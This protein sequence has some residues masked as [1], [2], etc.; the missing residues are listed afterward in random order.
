[1][2]GDAI[3]IVEAAY[4]LESDERDWGTKLLKQAAPRL[5]RGFGV[6]LA[7]FVPGTGFT[8]SSTVG[9]GMAAKL[10]EAMVALT[11]DDPEGPRRFLSNPPPFASGTQARGLTRE[12][13][14][15]FPPLVTRLHPLGVRDM[16]VV[17]VV[18][19]DTRP[20][21]LAAPTHD[22][23]RVSRK[24]AAFWARI[25]AHITAGARLRRSLS[26]LPGHVAE[27]KAEAVLSPSGALLH[28][29]PGA[30]ASSARESLR[31]AAKAIDRARSKGRSD[32]EEALDLWRG[33]VSGRWS[34][35]DQFDTDGRR[36]L[37]ALK[38]DPQVSDPRVLSLRERQVLAYTALG[39]SLKLI[40]YT[41]GFSTSNVAQHRANAMR[42]LGL[43]SYADVARL[44]ADA[45]TTT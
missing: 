28:A 3:S 45:A 16:V 1:V 30:Q 2:K 6:A 25:V 40:A 36:F 37:V 39:Y 32:D 13:A 10:V 5:E 38:N 22:V 44:F 17:S 42:K 24:D 7:E 8:E 15:T 19:P 43:T 23:C 33:L 21:A 12:E 9:L 26:G 11:H 29:E 4:D 27:E 34:L 41:L 20:F 35:V 14:L 18:G 31:S